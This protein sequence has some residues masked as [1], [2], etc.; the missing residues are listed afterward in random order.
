MTVSA[1]L[2]GAYIEFMQNEFN[3]T[4]SPVEGGYVVVKR[5]CCNCRFYKTKMTN[6]CMHPT[7]TGCWRFVYKEQQ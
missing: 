6:Y 4:H 7:S 1:T 2:I 5:S 3:V